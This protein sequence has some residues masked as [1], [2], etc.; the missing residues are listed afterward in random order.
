MF[1]RN[2]TRSTFHRSIKVDHS[3]YNTR[4]FEMIRIMQ[5][6]Y[7]ENILG[8]IIKKKAT[9]ENF[10]IFTQQFGTTDFHFHFIEH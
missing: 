9:L 2:E 4:T 5:I 8:I 6:Y 1:T 7:S 3:I 10:G